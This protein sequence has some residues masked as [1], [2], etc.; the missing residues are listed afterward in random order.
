MRTAFP[1]VIVAALVAACSVGEAALS[2]SERELISELGFDE[3]LMS[4]V[5]SLGDS[6]ERLTGTKDF[7]PL[8]ANGLVLIIAPNRGRAVLR[9]IRSALGGSPY[10]AYLNDEAFGYGAD[11]VAI[12]R[13]RDAFSLAGDSS[14]WLGDLFLAG[15]SQRIPTLPPS[16]RW[17]TRHTCVPAHRR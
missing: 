1:I 6:Y 3:S 12:V 5:K 10:R 8:P 4:R 13:S 11:R 9:K 15:W 16:Q 2:D 14:F 7:E 17:S